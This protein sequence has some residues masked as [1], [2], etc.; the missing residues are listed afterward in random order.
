MNRTALDPSIALADFAQAVGA[1]RSMDYALASGMAR[2]AASD[3]AGVARAFGSRK[4]VTPVEAEDALLGEYFDMKAGRDID[5]AVRSTRMD[6][7][8]SD[9]RV[10]DAAYA[11]S[12]LD[13]RQ[14]ARMN[15]DAANGDPSA[16]IRVSQR[17]YFG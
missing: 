11:Y 2:V 3:P 6:V 12:G 14:I 13:Q 1:G 17:F 7:A 10:S 4:V 16:A 15:F 9:R 8:E 5:T